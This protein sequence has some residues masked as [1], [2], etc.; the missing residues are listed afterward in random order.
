MTNGTN[1][2]LVN[3][4]QAENAIRTH[5]DLNPSID[6]PENR[7]N[8]DLVSYDTLASRAEPSSNGRLSHDSWSFGICDQSHRY[9]TKN[10]VGWRIATNARIGFKL[11]VTAT[12]EFHSLYDWCYQ[13]L[14][15]CSGGPGDPEDE[16]VMEMHGADALYSAVQSMMQAIRTEDQDTQQ[17][18]AHRIIQIAKPWTIRRWSESKLA[19]GKPHVWIQKENAH[20]LDLEW[21]EDEEAKLKTLVDRYTS[22]GA[23]G[24]WWVPSWRL[25]CFSVVLGDTEDQNEVSGQWYNEWPLDT[26]VDS[27]ILRWLRDT[28][29]PMLDNESG[30][31]SE[32]DENEASNEALLNEPDSHESTLL[33]APHPPQQAVLFCPLPGQDRHL[34]WWL[35]KF[36]WTIWIY[37]TCLRKWAMMIAQ[38]CSLNSKI[39]QIPL[40][41]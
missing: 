1:V 17:D 28:Y 41:L 16:T 36:L 35:T 32:P 39:P 10:F 11:Q 25:A 8:I 13:V 19:N 9:K 6:E 34:N 3:L 12:P 31:H 37:S 21:D 40:C 26:W 24:A 22:G 30:Q 2:K 38:K 27:L 33:C 15:L 23:S 18:A 14:W 7:W 29:L 4:L 20:L 5:E